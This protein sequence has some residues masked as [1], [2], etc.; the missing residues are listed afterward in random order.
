[1]ERP[2]HIEVEVSFLPTEHGGRKGPTLPGYRPQRYYANDDWDAVHT[3]PDVEEV[4]PGQTVTARLSIVN[5]TAHVGRINAGMPFLIREGQKVVGYG[6]VTRLLALE[7]VGKL[8]GGT[9]A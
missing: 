7:I 8:G 3:Y 1:M 9:D 6:R 2:D 4:W 5:P